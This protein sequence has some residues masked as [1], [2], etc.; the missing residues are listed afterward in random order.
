MP[1]YMFSSFTKDK[2]CCTSLK[3]DNESHN[4]VSNII[5][6]FMSVGSCLPSGEKFGRPHWVCKGKGRVWYLVKACPWHCT[7]L[8]WGWRW[9]F[10]KRQI[11]NNSS[12]YW[13]TFDSLLL[14]RL[15]VKYTI[16]CHLYHLL[17][18][19]V[20]DVIQYEQI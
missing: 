14:Q 16:H 4:N 19:T 5:S 18:I 15:K 2:Y 7:R 3:L 12:K 13:K 17:C 6:F 8:H 11:G 1:M 9:G 20:C 10:H